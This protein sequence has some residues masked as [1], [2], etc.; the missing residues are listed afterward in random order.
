[1][2]MCGMPPCRHCGKPVR[3]VWGTAEWHAS[4]DPVGGYCQCVSNE[5][6]Q[7]AE[8]AKERLESDKYQE[9]REA[10]ETYLQPKGNMQ[11]REDYVVRAFTRKNEFDRVC[12]PDAVLSALNELDRL[13]AEV[14]SLKEEPK[15]KVQAEALWSMA[16]VLEA[17]IKD[18]SKNALFR[19]GVQVSIAKLKTTAQM[20]MDFHEDYKWN[21][22]TVMEPL[23]K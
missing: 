1:M 11:S 9:M 16:S 5:F 2:S 20:L 23:P 4:H 10:C 19:S 13:R 21:A 8:A 12:G 15:W 14:A 17:E 18:E 6:R 22:E 7:L 3:T